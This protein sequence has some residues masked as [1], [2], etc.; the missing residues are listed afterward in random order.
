MTR[1]DWWYLPPDAPDTVPV[2]PVAEP[3]PGR[4][5]DLVDC[6]RPADPGQV[7]CGHHERTLSDEDIDWY[8]RHHAA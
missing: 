3:R 2:C 1:E 6:G 7:L 5:F 8:L 4:P